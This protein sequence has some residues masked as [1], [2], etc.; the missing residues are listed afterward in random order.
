MSENSHKH[1]R[2]ARDR[3]IDTLGIGKTYPLRDLDLTEDLIKVPFKTPAKI[4]IEIS[5]PDVLYSLYTK[6]GQPVHRAAGVPAESKGNGGTL[7]L[8]T[9]AIAQEITYKI[10]AA[11]IRS[12]KPDPECTTFLHRTA[13]VKVGLDIHLQAEI[14]D[15]EILDPANESPAN[16]D[17]RIV[18]Y[19]AGV[20]VKLK[21][22]QEGVD[23]RLVA[24][25]KKAGSSELEE[26]LL[27]GEPVRGTNRD[28]VL[29][30]HAVREDT[31]IRIRATKT[32]D[33]GENLPEDTELLEVVLPLK[34]RANPD[35]AVAVVPA[36]IVDH[37]QD[38]TLTISETQ[39]SA[40]YRLY[41]R[42]VADRDYVHRSIDA[43]KAIKVPVSGEPDVQVV[44]P[45]RSETWQEQ[46]GYA[47]L[48]E[49]LPGNGGDLNFTI[50]SLTDDS[51]IIIQALKHHA[52]NEKEPEV[53]II[54]SAIQLRM[55]AL[56]LAGPDPI[57]GLR[58]TVPVQDDK[59]SGTILVEGGQPG[60]FYYFRRTRQGKDLGFPAYF[61][62]HD[63][64]D[65]SQNKGLDQLKL[66][67]DFVVAANHPAGSVGEM[68]DPATITPQS[69]ILETGRLK[70]DSTLHIRAVKAQT[71]VKTPLDLTAPIGVLPDIRPEQATVNSGGKAR[72]L[73]VAS[74]AGDRYQ[75][76]LDGKPVKSARNG[77]GAD[78]VFITEALSRDTT[79][80][81][82]VT[83]PGAAGVP[84]VR[85]VKLPVKVNTGT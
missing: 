57:P 75:L 6:D 31:D 46:E 52:V 40:V 38:A 28:I 3:L 33:P 71:R 17:P 42:S 81:M 43:S 55:A 34:I 41:V 53:R 21:A 56:V 70:T 14:L 39:E 47:P 78:L 68:D 63:D 9:P 82:I 1:M 66:K 23:Y 4:A 8:E 67:I 2:A 7:I 84:V 59:T 19:G 64:R 54:P 80:E 45:E 20:D 69:P 73:V 72:I 65:E 11:K 29:P 32:F 50:Q 15:A 37:G 18:N 83:R 49:T 12:E 36:A 85:V 58:L 62:K 16:T 51:L 26:V 44:K 74:K 25:K 10:R 5:Q 61:H 60:V 13:T 48:L 24:L 77:N 79:F 30:S 76:T 35:L 22:S 27:S